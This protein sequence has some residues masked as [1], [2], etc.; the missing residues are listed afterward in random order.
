MNDQLTEDILHA[1]TSGSDVRY[2]FIA[3]LITGGIGLCLGAILYL[4]SKRRLL[5]INTEISLQNYAM[6]AAIIG[7]LFCAAALYTYATE[8]LDFRQAANDIAKAARINELVLCTGKCRVTGNRRVS[9]IT[10]NIFPDAH[11]FI[12]SPHDLQLKQEARL[13]TT[14]SIAERIV[15]IL[16]DQNMKVAKPQPVPE[17]GDV[18]TNTSTGTNQNNATLAQSEP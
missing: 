14:Q 12:I 1:I 18:E 10:P 13:V 8:L 3:F 5:T 16:E 11:T 4:L 6:A 9:C 2:Y 17:G 15:K 7:G